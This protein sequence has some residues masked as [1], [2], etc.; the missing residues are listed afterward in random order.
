MKIKERS[1]LTNSTNSR[2]ILQQEPLRTNNAKDASVL[3]RKI[4][5][6]TEGTL[7]GGQSDRVDVSLAK[8]ISAEFSPDT[9]A[10]E[11][12]SKVERLKQLVAEGKYNPSSEAV[13]RSVGEE[14]MFEIF[15]AQGATTER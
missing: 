15:G 4:K 12:R 6:E 8:A 13:A 10:A 7:I 14:I 11:R 5:A 9:M 1:E 3:A 2:D